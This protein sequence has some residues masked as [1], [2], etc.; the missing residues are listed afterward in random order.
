MGDGE[1]DYKS[2]RWP[3]KVQVKQ[4]ETSNVSTVR[5]KYKYNTA[6]EDRIS[7]SGRIVGTGAE[8]G[9]GKASRREQNGEKRDPPRDRGKRHGKPPCGGRKS[10]I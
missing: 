1:D 5:N 9:K 2:T 6:V 4:S 10:P 3:L 7:E 8:R